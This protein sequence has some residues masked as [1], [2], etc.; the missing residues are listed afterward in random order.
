MFET[1]N[2]LEGFRWTGESYVNFSS[3]LFSVFGFKD[4]LLDKTGQISAA[5]WCQLQPCRKI[6][7]IQ[8]TFT[9]Q[10]CRFIIWVSPIVARGQAQNLSDTYSVRL[11][12]EP[13]TNSSSISLCFLSAAFSIKRLHI[14]DHHRCYPPCLC[15]KSDDA[16]RWIHAMTQFISSKPA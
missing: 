15:R 9:Y 13:Q 10:P 11:S 12:S 14:P 6:P 8:Y 7:S 2:E 16:L 1:R 3:L 4:G 5:I